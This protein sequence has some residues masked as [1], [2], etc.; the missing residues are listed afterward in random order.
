MT[1]G[2]GLFLFE[3]LTGMMRERI[4][5]YS[6]YLLYFAAVSLSVWGLKELIVSYWPSLAQRSMRFRLPTEGALFL[7][8][9]IVLFVGSMIGKSNTLM[10]VFALFAGSLIMNGNMAFVMLR[11]LSISRELPKRVMVG[12]PFTV[13]MTLGN[14]KWWLSAWVMICRDL[15]RHHQGSLRPEIVF[16][17]VP[18]K[19]KQRGHYELCL[20]KRGEYIFGPTT[21]DTRFPLGLIERGVSFAE[22]AQLLVYPRIGHMLPSWRSR[23][24]HAS[25]LVTYVQPQSGPF[26]DEMHSTREYR[27]GDDTR[28]IHWRTSARMNELMV[29]EY[30]ESRDRHLLVIVDVWQDPK[31]NEANVELLLRFAATLCLDQQ[32]NSR[33]TSLNVRLVG[34]KT[35][36]W[37]GE[38]GDGQ[39]EQMLDL[40]AVV[41]STTNSNPQPVLDSLVELRDKNRRV[42]LLSTRGKLIRQLIQQSANNELLNGEMQVLGIAPEEIGQLY[43]DQPH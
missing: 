34:K 30:R 42:L 38:I 9:M 39:T 29:K 15:V 1:V 41:E 16:M 33:E 28:L 32:R 25:E 40:F 4:G 18:P 3:L 36:D 14:G 11:S 23:I 26:N 31:L 6:E 37:L 17:R 13:T 5:G 20:H 10:M 21:V 35:L 43:D 24:T 7:I 8:I 19:S 27:P 22:Q 12:E 2:L